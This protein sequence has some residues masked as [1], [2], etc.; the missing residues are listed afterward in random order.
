MKQQEPIKA[1]TDGET[2]AIKNL[3]VNG[4]QGAPYNT[5]IKANMIICC[6]EQREKALPHPMAI[7]SHI[8]RSIENK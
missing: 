1:F 6:L 4:I 3:P 8:A 5:A 7:D 2:E